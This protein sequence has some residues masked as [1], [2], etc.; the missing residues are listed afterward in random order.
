M[1]LCLF[2]C[3]VLL[4]EPEWPQPLHVFSWAGW[5]LVYYMPGLEQNSEMYRRFIDDGFFLW[6]GSEEELQTLQ[7]L[8]PNH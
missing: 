5:K 1:G 3:L 7:Q 2:S 4:W 6:D 8:S